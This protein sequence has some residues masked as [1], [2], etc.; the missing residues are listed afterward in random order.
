MEHLG[1]AHD[2]AGL[3]ALLEAGRRRIAAEQGQGPLDLESLELAPGRAGP[4]GTTVET[5]RSGLLWD[6][7]HRGPTPAWDW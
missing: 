6:V 5:R 2:E 1:S 7:L 4:A 3:A